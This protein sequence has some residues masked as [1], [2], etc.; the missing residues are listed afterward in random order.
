L[1]TKRICKRCSTETLW[2]KERSYVW[3]DEDESFWEGDKTVR[4]PYA[5][6]DPSSPLWESISIEKSPPKECPFSL[7]HLMEERRGE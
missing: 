5:N 4:C 6:S 7:E 2:A 3:T 1:L